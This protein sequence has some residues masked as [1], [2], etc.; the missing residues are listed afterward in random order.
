MCCDN[1]R[2][3][4]ARYVRPFHESWTEERLAIAPASRA[5]RPISPALRALRFPV[6][7]VL[8]ARL[9]TLSASS[10]H[11]SAGSWQRTEVS[12]ILRAAPAHLDSWMA[13]EPHGRVERGVADSAPCAPLPVVDSQHR[14]RT[15]DRSASCEPPR[16]RDRSRAATGRFQRRRG[17]ERRPADPNRFAAPDTRQGRSPPCDAGI[18][19]GRVAARSL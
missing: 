19:Q 9:Q 2:R 6:A 12:R 7:R 15:N 13:P 17:F 4:F 1:R 5:Q 14:T 18:E 3:S 8:R 10:P 11:R 16:P